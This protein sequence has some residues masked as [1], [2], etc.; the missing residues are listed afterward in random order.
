MAEASPLPFDRVIK[1]FVSSTFRDM[2][3]E[4]EE[5][6]KF[7]FPKLRAICEARGVVWGEVDL[8]W[9]I[10][11]EQKA[12]GQVLPICLKEIRRCRPYFI[13][14]LG[15]RYGSVPDS[16]PEN[17]VAKETWLDGARDRSVTELEILHG[18]LNDPDMAAHAF[19]YFRDPAYIE[20]LPERDRPDHTETPAAADVAA[21]GEAEAARLAAARHDKIIRL[22]DRIRASGF[23]VRESFRD[24]RDLGRLVLEDMIRLI[25]SLFPADEKPDTLGL[26]AAGHESHIRA[27]SRVYVARP[28]DYD[29]IDRHV[30]SSGAPLVVT[31]EPG[32]GKSALL[33]NW[34]GHFREE[35][36]DVPVIVH[37]VRATPASV[38][39]ASMLRR[40]ATEL[41]RTLDLDLDIPVE[42]GAMRGVFSRALAMAGERGRAVVVIDGLDRLEGHAGPS[43]ANWLPEAI[44][45]SIR[46]VL[47]CSPD[48]ILESLY[49]RGWPAYEVA[50]LAPED[51]RLF[52]RKYLDLHGKTLSRPHE[53]MI[54]AAELS[55]NPLFLKTL[56]EELRIFGSHEELE[57]RLADYLRAP[58]VPA[59]FSLV[60]ARYEE[61]YDRD[62]PGLVG[63]AFSLFYVANRGLAESELLDLLGTDGAPLPQAIWAPLY[64]AA[65]ESLL[66][67]RGGIL[68]LNSP[69]IRTALVVAFP[70]PGSAAALNRRLVQYFRTRENGP[71]KLEELPAQL[72]MA[73]DMALLRDVMADLPFL[74]AM[75]ERDLS[76]A[77]N[78]WERLER[79]GFDFF[80]T[81]RAVLKDPFEHGDYVFPVFQVMSAL[82]HV[83]QS[84]AFG[85]ILAEWLK[86]TEDSE[87]TA[88]AL[89][90]LGILFERANDLGEALKAHEA[91]EIRARE[92]S[93]AAE[94][95]RSLS[96]RTGV[97]ARLGRLDEALASS[98]AAAAIYRERQ[99]RNGFMH[100]ALDQAQILDQRDER[101]AARPLFEEAAAIARERG[102]NPTLISALT[103]LSDIARLAGDLD[104]AEK[105]L[106]EIE[107]LHG[108]GV[109]G[110]RLLGS[111][112]SLKARI[113]IERGH[114]EEAIRLFGQMRELGLEQAD[115]RLESEGKFL[116]AST[117]YNAGEYA[118]AL[119]LYQEVGRTAR[120]IGDRII[121][122]SSLTGEARSLDAMKQTDAAAR[123][124]GEAEALGAEMGLTKALVELLGDHASLLYTAGRFDEAHA[125]WDRLDELVRTI[126]NGKTPGGVLL[127]RAECALIEANWD[128]ARRLAGELGDRI[129]EGGHDETV[130][131]FLSIRARLFF[132]DQQYREAIALYS[133][134]EALA[135]ER[136][137]GKWLG[138]ALGGEALCHHFLNDDERS[139][140]AFTEAETVLR[141]IGRW[142]WLTDNLLNH[143]RILKEMGRRAESLE[144]FRG[145]AEAAG[146]AGKMDLVRI[147]LIDQFAAL[148]ELMRTDEAAVVL[149]EAERLCREAGDL[150][151]LRMTLTNK[152]AHL[153][154][155]GKHAETI[156][157]LG[158]AAGL[159][160]KAGDEAD[161]SRILGHLSMSYWNAGRQAEAREALLERE[162]LCRSLGDAKGLA[163]T[164]NLRA[165]DSGQA[166]DGPGAI[167]LS[168][169]AEKLYRSIGDQDGLRDTLLYLA[170]AHYKLSRYAEAAALSEQGE[171]LDRRAGRKDRL[172]VDLAFRA[173]ALAALG[174]QAEAVALF[175]EQEALLR[176]A[177]RT[178]D[179]AVCLQN[180]GNLHRSMGNDQ[181]ARKVYADAEQA[182]RAAGDSAT[183]AHVL[184][185]WSG[186]LLALAAWDEALA[187]WPRAERVAIESGDQR[188]LWYY[189]YVQA[190]TLAYRKGDARAAMAKI[191][192]LAKLPGEACPDENSGK[193]VMEMRSQLLAHLGRRS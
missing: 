181:R 138:E 175:E 63:D 51:R 118:A 153:M 91:A 65:A 25:D 17:L 192:D 154:R 75:V 8:R 43:D 155:L 190:H 148:H 146:K 30:T 187:L 186:M 104:T 93:S 177:G 149:G 49:R 84:V 107:S 101:E 74:K 50:P 31:G 160:R 143:A 144:V 7:V 34:V 10:T 87:G 3:A 4:R 171:A 12:E 132:H 15:E 85:K 125:L 166:G 119:A 117:R 5:L 47:G 36:P 26:E 109:P 173:G 60:L 108:Q 27:L 121:L 89:N 14:I 174:R 103:H 122:F 81:Y 176:E 94:L 13:G 52:I 193:A 35:H 159:A 96:C 9:G 111:F 92:A 189:L 162:R 20:S 180:Q 86:V 140:A 46:L 33:A 70:G 134:L 172:Q 185:N 57:G 6:L 165:W 163:E 19:F 157:V 129:G 23:P 98:R 64:V 112:L 164:L 73:D 141:E 66:A 183:L 59:L 21:F 142:D 156:P 99:D 55:A 179:L 82:D 106:A 11:D 32:C 184:A 1:V 169:E 137:E 152:A 188:G 115:V 158:E 61:D 72:W 97:L 39:E 151:R 28:S 53:D 62:R 139:V 170:E 126:E 168:G 54:V 102:A 131:G 80:E 147:S 135:R 130:R 48:P 150:P 76:T 178:A 83:P 56:V 42:A 120:D 24:P 78:I 44:P 90:N 58:T 114:P 123:L 95:A 79:E 16:V 40:L 128:E 77:A 69:L 191:D 18:V 136:N 110:Y 41:G 161:L 100:T 113:E 22:K 124:Y 133:R 29:A 45:P 167:A 145:L 127:H 68:S 182:A 88:L 2:R 105:H 116:E 67:E 37:F 71:R 38:E